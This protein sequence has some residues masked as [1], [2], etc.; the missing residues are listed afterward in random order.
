MTLDW[1]T[2]RERNSLRE[3]A[4]LEKMVLRQNVYEHGMNERA[5]ITIG[6]WLVLGAADH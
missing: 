3:K 4:I 5:E 2:K 6:A 1:R